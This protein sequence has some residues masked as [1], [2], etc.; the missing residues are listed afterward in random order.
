MAPFGVNIL[1]NGSA[2]KNSMEGWEVV[3]SGGDGWKVERPP[4]GVLPPTDNACFVTS[5]EECARRQTI[6]LE[7]LS[8]LEKVKP[9]LEFTVWVA[10]RNDC[11]AKYS[12]T[13]RQM[14]AKGQV[15]DTREGRRVLS[16]GK[17][18][19]VEEVM[20]WAAGCSQVEVT[21]R[22]QDTKCWKGWYGAKVT[23]MR[24][25]LHVAPPLYVNLLVNG[26]AERNSMGGW[27]LLSEYDDWKVEEPPVGVPLPPCGG[28]ACFV[29]S[30]GKCARRQTIKLEEISTLEKLKPELVFTVWVANKSGCKAKYSYTVRQ[31]DAKGQVLD[32]REGSRELTE[33]DW[34][35]VEEVMPWAAGCS[36]V[37]VTDK[38]QAMHN[39]KEWC[40]AKVTGMQVVLRPC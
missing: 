14:D 2:Q 30:Y 40:G 22:G 37:E 19:K 17:W 5:Y 32:T 26:G 35:E 4:I 13:V 34:I 15:L 7:E 3:A 12:Y 18:R 20:P 39:R 27:E 9:K 6:K 21:D 31:R 23:G 16:T 24:V 25:V 38:G 11:R 28:D 10:N 33:D 29:T 8:V 36:Q 1:V